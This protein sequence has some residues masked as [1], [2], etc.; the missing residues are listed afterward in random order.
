[1]KEKAF[2]CVRMKAEIQQKLQEELAGLSPEEVE[3]VAIQRISN[4]PPMGR[5][6][7]EAR[8]CSLRAR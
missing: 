6:W 8:R 7:R 4:D 5:L 3:N 2:D 1:M